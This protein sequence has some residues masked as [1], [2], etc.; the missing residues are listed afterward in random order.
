[1]ASRGMTRTRGRGQR[2]DVGAAE[3][4]LQKSAS[5][6]ERALDAVAEDPE[7]AIER[8]GQFLGKLVGTVEQARDAYVKDPEGVKRQVRG[9]VAGAVAEQLRK[10]RQKT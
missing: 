10:R 4:I 7:A 9:A 5:A 8:A 3:R 6:L 1:M 2:L